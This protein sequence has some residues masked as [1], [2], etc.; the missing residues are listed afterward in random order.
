MKA[1][2]ADLVRI[3]GGNAYVNNPAPEKAVG[4]AMATRPHSWGW[5][6]G[7][8]V[9]EHV[10][11]RKGYDAL[12]QIGSDDPRDA[13][14]CI[15]QVRK[16]LDVVHFSMTQACEDVPGS[17]VGHQRTYSMLAYKAP[18]LGKN[19][20]VCHIAVHPNWVSGIDSERH[21]VV[22]EYVRSMEVLRHML[23]FAEDMGWLIVVTGDFN[24]RKGDDKTF[25]T[26]YDVFADFRLSVRT[27]G[28]DGVAW[29]RRLVL[30]GWHLI[31]KRRTRSDHDFWTVADF[32]RKGRKR[33]AA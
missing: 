31:P 25:E 13:N 30:D 14:D 6:E 32:R 26:V 29:D 18:M 33:P 27:E 7:M 11:G 3:G 22:R 5:S 24:S 20:V 1:P 2:A 9:I 4:I 15:M 12:T 23:A 10:R 8:G 17:K 21:P 16:G 19:A 28:I